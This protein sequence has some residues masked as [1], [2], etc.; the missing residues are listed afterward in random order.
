MTTLCLLCLACLPALQ[1][2]AA[3]G[4]DT[5]L[6]VVP[7]R[8]T[9]LQ[10][11]FDVARLRSSFVVTYSQ[12][13]DDALHI[14]DSDAGRWVGITAEE[15][16][17]GGLFQTPPDNVII[18]GS[19][20][21]LPGILSEMPTWA[22]G[23]KMI[24]SSGMMALA[25]G[26]NGVVRFSSREWKWIAARYGLKLKDLNAAKRRYGRYG[27]PGSDGPAS[28]PPVPAPKEHIMGPPRALD[29]PDRP[30]PGIVVPLEGRSVLLP[31]EEESDDA[32]KQILEDLRRDIGK[33]Q[34]EPIKEPAPAP[35]VDTQPEDK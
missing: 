5:L 9:I 20:G 28:P 15:F 16:V 23:G 10:F 18:V 11:S 31:I 25:N 14:W 6:L 13:G 27:A 29:E 34:A 22:K 3:E 2:R 19:G 33:Q 21:E 1:P 12:D 17:S 7:A 26:V 24:N 35:A 4:S 30:G 8:H 32:S